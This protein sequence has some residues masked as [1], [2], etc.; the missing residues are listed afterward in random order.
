[1]TP[2]TAPKTRKLS[3]ERPNVGYVR[4]EF[5]SLKPRWDLIR[6]VLA[7]SEEVKKRGDVYLPRP[8]ASDESPENEERYKAYKQRAVF[9]NATGRTRAG[10]VGQV[11]SVDPVITLPASLKALE[12]DVDGAGLSLTQQA[13]KTL[14]NV[15]SYG[16]YGL[17]TDYPTVEGEGA[18]VAQLA[19][20]NIRPNIVTFDAWDLIN[21]RTIRVG[22]VVKLALV[23]I[24]EQYVADDD[25]FE[26][27][28]KQCWKVLRLDDD[29]LYVVEEYEQATNADG[30]QLRKDKDGVDRVFKPTDSKRQRLSYIPFTFVGAVNNDCEPDLPPLYDLADLNIAHYRNSADYEEAAYIVGQPTPY[31][32]GLTQ[33]WVDDVLKGAIQLGARAAVPLPEGGT[34]G[35][36]QA[37]PNTMP[38]EAMEHKEKQMVALGAKLVEQKTVQR[39]ATESALDGAAE[40]SILG[41]IA[42][43]VSAAYV[44][45][46]EWANAF[47]SPTEAKVV[48]ALNTNFRSNSMNAQE[49]AQLIAEWQAQAITDDEMREAMR[50]SGLA[51]ETVEEWQDKRETQALTQP[52]VPPGKAAPAKA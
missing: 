35:L 38:F 1:M 9:Y 21:W 17:W 32:A 34:A 41:Q 3:K 40:Q 36:L 5:A 23:V 4:P 47:V 33:G 43:N 7:G 51:T 20:G 12:A 25:G 48:F 28:Y 45:H 31:F 10:L 37:S 50:R 8:N 14:S 52:I 46:L 11:M 26:E 22:G 19:A 44:A 49:R 16:R 39:T 6:D 13:T 42:K 27:E 30:Y 18:T 2:T 15:L 29:G 24:D